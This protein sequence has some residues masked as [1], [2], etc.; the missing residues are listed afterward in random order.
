[1]CRAYPLEASR[2]PQKSR[3][4]VFGPPRPQSLIDNLVGGCAIP[5]KFIVPKM[6]SESKAVDRGVITADDVAIAVEG[7]VRSERS[8]F[9]GCQHVWLPSGTRRESA[10]AMVSSGAAGYL[11]CSS[12]FSTL[13]VS[14]QPLS[15]LAPPKKN[16]RR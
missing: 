16:P 6:M 12:Y 10:A 8:L 5:S 9:F 3:A 2:A 11:G 15:Y 4:A 1:M 7:D 13:F 14:P